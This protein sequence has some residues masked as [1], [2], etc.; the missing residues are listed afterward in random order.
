MDWRLARNYGRVVEHA[1]PVAPTWREI[2]IGGLL[3]TLRSRDF[4]A[5]LAMRCRL[6]DR[7]E[8]AGAGPMRSADGICDS[9][10]GSI[11]SRRR[12]FRNTWKTGSM[13]TIQFGQ[14]M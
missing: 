10:R 14:S 13:R 2:A 3:R 6:A 8:K 7:A 11:A 9:S 1:K 4:R 12:C 5:Q